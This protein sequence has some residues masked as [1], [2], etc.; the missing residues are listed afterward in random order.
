M[1]R[2][3]ILAIVLWVGSCADSGGS[4]PQV[5]RGKLVAD[6][7]SSL[8]PFVKA[9][10][11]AFV[12]LHPQVAFDIKNGGSRVGIKKLTEG[13]AGDRI[14]F[15]KSSRPILRAELDAAEAR[16]RHIHATVVAAEAIVVVV[17]P[18]NPIASIRIE[19]LKAIYYSG[20]TLDWADIPGSG[21]QGHIKAI[22][23]DP[24]ISGTGQMFT[25]VVGGGDTPRYSRAVQVVPD[26]PDLPGPVL[27]DVDALGFC[28]QAV[29]AGTKLRVL[30]LN[31][32]RPSEMTVLDTSYLLNRRL[33]VLTDGPAVG[34]MAD[35]LL[36]LLGEPGQRIARERGF[37]PVTLDV[38]L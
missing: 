16:G 27:A 18:G 4:A 31:N 24:K 21:R 29:A 34:L 20:A 37:T 36:F 3:C 19:D 10:A 33:Y 8:H 38:A 11:E 30:K 13:E 26:N 22:G 2:R 6:G 14:D 9:A 32:V 5:V 35:F 23:I 12:G 28:S 25:E 1:S 7:S 15:A 17:H